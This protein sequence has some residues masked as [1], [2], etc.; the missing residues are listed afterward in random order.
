MKIAIV[1]VGYLTN[2][3]Y[4]KNWLF[5]YHKSETSLECILIY[6]KRT[7]K[8]ILEIWPYKKYLIDDNIIFQR[9]KPVLFS[10]EIKN[11]YYVDLIKISCYDYIGDCIVVDYDTIINKKINL[12]TIPD[13]DIAAC[14]HSKYSNF[15]HKKKLMSTMVN[16]EEYDFI[17]YINLGVIILRKSIKNM[18][19][20]YSMKYFSMLHKEPA[21]ECFGQ[22]IASLVFK[23]M[24]AVYLDDSWNW[25][26]DSTVNNNSAIITHY[27]GPPAKKILTRIINQQV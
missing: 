23:K 16:F 4:L 1:A 26:G 15:Y 17:P 2:I 27:W 25:H 18:F 10:Y 8:E 6:D 9:C 24:Q 11:F 20:E 13:C 22:S 3:N 7:S 14:S 21:M 12:D 5:Y 19:I